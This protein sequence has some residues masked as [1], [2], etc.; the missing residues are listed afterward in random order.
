MAMQSAGRVNWRA[1]VGPVRFNIDQNNKQVNAYFNMLTGDI[2]LFAGIFDIY[3]NQSM[4]IIAHEIAHSIDFRDG[5]IGSMGLDFLQTTGETSFN[6]FK[7]N[8]MRHY[9]CSNDG[10]AWADAFAA[11]V[12]EYSPGWIEAIPP[13]RNF[14]L[15]GSKLFGFNWNRK[16]VVDGARNTLLLD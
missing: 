14:S 7:R 3:A 10:E 6:R 5:E 1:S 8:C 4:F 16:A 13:R 15:A 11:L 12:T 9:T 2:T